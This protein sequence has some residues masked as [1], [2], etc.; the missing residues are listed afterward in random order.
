[1][2]SH[3]RNLA[4]CYT[5]VNS[6][7][8]IDVDLASC[9]C[10]EMSENREEVRR[11]ALLHLI[12]RSVPDP[13]P[14]QK[15]LAE[16]LGFSPA[17]FTQMKKGNR[18]IGNDSAERIED[19][20]ALGR[21]GLDQLGEKLSRGETPSNVTPLGKHKRPLV[22]QLCDLADKIHDDGLRDLI[23]QAKQLFKSHPL[24]SK[25]NRARS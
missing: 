15:D 4:P 8:G 3:G 18:S 25:A 22:Q 20:F 10:F 5:A 13:Y 7:P 21:G 9:Y 14:R 16:D 6:T 19:V 2:E 24:L 12:G 17:H 11:R 1:M 23:G